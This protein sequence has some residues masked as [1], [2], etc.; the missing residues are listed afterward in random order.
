VNKTAK[1]ATLLKEVQREDAP[2]AKVCFALLVL[3]DQPESNPQEREQAH[4][5][6]LKRTQKAGSSPQKEGS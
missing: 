1:E 3:P 5:T 4:K 6:G 2:S